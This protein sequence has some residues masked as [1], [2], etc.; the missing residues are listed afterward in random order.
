MSNPTNEQVGRYRM[1]LEAIAAMRPTNDTNIP[2]FV[3]LMVAIATI[4]LR[5]GGGKHD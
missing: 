3:A 4:A 5:Q 1:A 2:E